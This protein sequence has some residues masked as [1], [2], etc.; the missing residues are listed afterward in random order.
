MPNIPA[1]LARNI[2]YFEWSH[3]MFQRYLP[4]SAGVLALLCVTGMPGQL[5]AQHGRGAFR[6]GAGPHVG[7]VGAGFGTRVIAPRFDG[8]SPGFSTPFVDRRF[9]VF[10]PGLGTRV[11]D[12]R[13]G[14]FS[15]GFG[16]PFVERRFGGFRPDFDRRFIERRFGEF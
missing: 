15:P 1:H 2:F 8:F 7:R 4:L 10:T 5:Y 11:I 6:S 14:G 3:A 16:A 13:V 12:T 9:G